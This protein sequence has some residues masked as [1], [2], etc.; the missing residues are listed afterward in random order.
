MMEFFDSMNMVEHEAVVEEEEETIPAYSELILATGPLYSP[1]NLDFHPEVQPTSPFVDQPLTPLW[2]F[3]DNNCDFSARGGHGSYSFPFPF[4][5]P[6]PRKSGALRSLVILDFSLPPNICDLDFLLPPNL[7]RLKMSFPWSYSKLPLLLDMT[8]LKSLV[9]LMILV[10]VRIR[11]LRKVQEEA[12][13]V[14]TTKF[15]GDNKLD[16][17]H[18]S[19]QGPQ[20]YPNGRDMVQIDSSEQQAVEF[21]VRH[22]GGNIVITGESDT[23]VAGS[24]RKNAKKISK[25]K[26]TNTETFLSPELLQQLKG[27]MTLDEIAECT[28][29]SRSSIKRF[30]RKYEIPRWPRK[31]NESVHGVEGAPSQPCLAK[32]PLNDGIGRPAKLNKS[33]QRNLSLAFRPT[34]LSPSSPYCVSNTLASMRPQIS[35]ERMLTEVQ[36]CPEYLKKGKGNETVRS[37]SNPIPEHT[38]TSVAPTMLQ[39]IAMQDVSTMTIKVRY[40]SEIL[41]FP[42]SLSSG[43][44]ELDEKISKRLELKLGTFRIKYQDADGDWVGIYCDEDLQLCM[45]DSKRLGKSTIIMSVES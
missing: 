40:R 6:F 7:H 22:N 42:L 29:A 11:K 31:R 23:P 25:R 21:D 45:G 15:S 4:P 41:R 18:E 2:N 24:E 39:V 34:E 8:C 35:A 38:V 19:P 20:D 44:R 33:N 43:K 37:C 36:G 13:S 10:S 30:C 9:Y 5:F 26:H 28:G 16:S 27:R 1:V 14:E 32:D 17:N 3:Q 12:I